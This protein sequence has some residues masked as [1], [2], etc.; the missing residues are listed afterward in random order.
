VELPLRA[1]VRG[2]RYAVIGRDAWT[3]AGGF[4]QDVRPQPGEISRSI[5]EDPKTVFWRSWNPMSGS[6]P[7][8]VVSAPFLPS[9]VL[10]IPFAGY[11]GEPGIELY[12]EC[13]ATGSRIPVAYGIAHET[14]VESTLWLPSSWRP[15]P[16]RLVAKSD[17]RRRYVAV[18]T[19]VRSSR[20]V[21]LKQS[22]F[23]IASGA[24]PC[25][26]RAAGAGPRDCQPFR[27][28]Q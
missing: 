6:E 15:S 13:V 10:A 4:N 8:M 16:V 24:C 27:E 5:A 19:P 14:W 2:Y 25:V 1:F 26:A 7:G 22:V 20:L 18:G 9:P 3:A 23:A 21:W 17:S 11:P 12:L 28:A